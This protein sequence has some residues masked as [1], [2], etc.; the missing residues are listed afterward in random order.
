VLLTRLDDLEACKER[1]RIHN[2]A[3]PQPFNYQGTQVNTASDVKEKWFS[4]CKR[5]EWNDEFGDV[6]PEDP[7]LED[8]LFIHNYST[9]QGEKIEEYREFPIT[10]H[11]DIKVAPVRNVS[12]LEHILISY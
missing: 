1:A 5:Y 8:E 12:L 2:W 6:A 10:L 3:V 9:I 7:E 4:G 11:G